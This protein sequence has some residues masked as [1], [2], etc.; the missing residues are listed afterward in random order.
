VENSPVTPIHHKK[1]GP[2][3]A[4]CILLFLCLILY[5]LMGH[6]WYHTLSFSFLFW[7]TGE[8][9]TLRELMKVPNEPDLSPNNGLDKER[10]CG[11][12]KRAASSP[13]VQD[14]RKYRPYVYKCIQHTGTEKSTAAGF[15][16]ALHH[17][18]PTYRSLMDPT[19]LETLST[20]AAGLGLGVIRLFAF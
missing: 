19:Q 11:P 16:R 12:K 9:S 2:T 5:L 17:A 14:C 7:V 8:L 6:R 4:K 1:K 13:S 20:C 10:P 18:P 15:A 3:L